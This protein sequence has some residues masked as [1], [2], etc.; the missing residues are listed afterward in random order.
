M[1]YAD[2]KGMSEGFVDKI[3]SQLQGYRGEDVETLVVG[4]TGEHAQI[5]AVDSSGIAACCDDIG[6]AA[7]GIGAWHAKSLLMQRGY[8]NLADFA[9]ALTATFAANKNAEVAPG[10]GKYTDINLISQ[11]GYIE[12]VYD[13]TRDKLD[14]LYRKFD[15]A[16]DSLVST[17]IEELGSFMRHQQQQGGASIDASQQGQDPGSDEKT[18]GGSGETTTQ[19]ARDEVGRDK[20]RG[21]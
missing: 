19:A 15:E 6:F 2:Q 14:E 5:Y 11:S 9:T 12:R 16:R 7:I 18:H 10:V 20:A 17:T 1:F 4:S 21:G 3:S 8:S 13:S